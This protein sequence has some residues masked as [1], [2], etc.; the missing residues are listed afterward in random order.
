MDLRI[1]P[2]ERLLLIP[3]AKGAD[4]VSVSLTFGVVEN[5]PKV[6]HGAN[7]GLWAESIWLPAI[8]L[9][10]GRVHWESVDDATAILVVPFGDAEERFVVRFD[11]DSG[12]V[13]LFKA[14]RYKGADADGKTLWLNEARAWGAPGGRPAL[15]VGAAIWLDDGRPWAVFSVDEI[16]YNVDIDD[17]IMASGP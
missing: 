8:F 5:E 17:Y 1:E 16:V 12:L 13:Q 6:D 15:T 3:F 11:P 4:E 9:S 7:L 10:D 14:M 2:M